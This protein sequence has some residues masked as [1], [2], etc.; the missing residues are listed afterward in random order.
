MDSQVSASIIAVIGT[1]LGALVV[2]WSN[3]QSEKI[4]RYEKRIEKYKAEII[5]RQYEEE[6]AA[7]WLFDI[8]V[9]T[10]AIAAKKELRKRTLEMKGTRPKISPSE[11]SST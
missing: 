7:N 10:S 5:A 8:G 4:A 9:S 11:I 3:R 1:V 2:V 6:V